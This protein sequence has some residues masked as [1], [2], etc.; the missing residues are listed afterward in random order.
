MAQEWMT[1]RPANRVNGNGR[2]RPA[3]G[4]STRAVHGGAR[5]RKAY[6]ALT[7][8]IVQTATYAFNDTQELID[9]MDRK[10]P[11]VCDP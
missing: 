8:P 6:G 2:Q 4:S 3:L 1:D 9:F 5:R 10:T 11:P 7:M